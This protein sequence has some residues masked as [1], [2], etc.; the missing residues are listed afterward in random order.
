MKDFKTLLVWRKAHELSLAVYKNTARFPMDEKYGLTSQ[1]RRCC[2]SIE[3][4]IAE[5]CA[6][7]GDQEFRRFLFISTGS[8][9]ELDCHLLLARDLELLPDTAYQALFKQLSEVR[10]MLEGLIRTIDRS[11]EAES[12]I[13]LR[14]RGTATS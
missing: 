1:V 9:S 12:K 14:G 4:N 7:D 10:S 6:R 5:G 13:Q 11:S 8:A 2:V 3:A